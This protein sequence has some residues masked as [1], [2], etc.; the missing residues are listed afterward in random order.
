[1]LEEGGRIQACLGRWDWSRIMSVTVLSLSLKY[2]LMGAALAAGKWF[3]PLPSIPRPGEKL[4]QWLVTH[5]GFLNPESGRILLQHLNN[6]ALQE[7]IGQV[8]SLFEPSARMDSLFKG[9]FRVDT[10]IHLAV[11]DLRGDTGPRLGKIHPAGF[12]L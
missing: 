10:I 1:V 4:R 8:F 3:A 11:K 7:N 5:M 2:R 6:S 9:F 12:D